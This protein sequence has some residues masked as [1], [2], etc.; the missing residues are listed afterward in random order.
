ITYI[1]IPDGGAGYKFMRTNNS[2]V[3]QSTALFD[4]AMFPCC[5]DSR[6]RPH[7]RLQTAPPSAETEPPVPDLWIDSEDFLPQPPKPSEKR[8][9]NQGDDPEV[10]QPAH[11][12][13]PPSPPPGEPQVPPVPLRHSGR[14]RTAP[15]RPGMP[16]W[17]QLVGEPSRT[18]STTK[19]RQQIQ[20]PGPSSAPQPPH[21]HSPQ[22]PDAPEQGGANSDQPS[23]EEV[24]G[25]LVAKLC[26]EGGVK[27][28]EYLLMK[29]IP[30]D[31]PDTSNV[32]EWTFRDILHLKPK[33]Q[34]E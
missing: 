14:E 34:K 9:G 33:V 2:I 5:S 11:Q 18:R 28:A 25:I 21:D 32:R 27:L 24:E 1:G 4:E 31:D 6:K 10:Q 8:S 7:T 13:N 15:S 3:V 20:V 19:A 26:R 30:A 17:K 22:P 12:P 16:T 23:E 29:A